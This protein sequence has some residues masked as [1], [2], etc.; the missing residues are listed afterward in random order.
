MCVIVCVSVGKFTGMVNLTAR[1]S[2]DWDT[3]KQ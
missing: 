2:A 1:I 3:V